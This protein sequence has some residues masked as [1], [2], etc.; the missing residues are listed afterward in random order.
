MAAS[1]EEGDENERVRA[2]ILLGCVAHASREPE[3]ARDWWEQSVTLARQLESE[4]LS[5]ALNNLAALVW[6]QGDLAAATTLFEEC[7][8]AARSA[9]STEY[10]AFALMGLGDV[11]VDLGNLVVGRAQLSEA[12]ALFAG[13]GFQ[14]GVASCCVYL[15]VVPE[16]EGDLALAA[17]LTGAAVGL[18]K[19]TGASPDWHERELME[20]LSARL[21]L[22]LGEESYAEAAAAGEAAPD[23]VVEEVLEGSAST[24]SE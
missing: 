8:A 18:R 19:L 7:L 4:H 24:L 21:R 14:E 9:G 23:Q 20:K 13:L 12:L 16:Q 10:A 3:S 1:A 15:A 2:L 5:V 22:A 11:N 6:E 17:R